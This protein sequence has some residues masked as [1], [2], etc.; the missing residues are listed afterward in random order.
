MTWYIYIV[1]CSDESLYTGITR[2]VASRITQHNGGEGAKYTRTR[3][4]VE[5][6]YMEKANSRS[7]ALRREYEIKRMRSAGKR[8]LI[9]NNNNILRG[10]GH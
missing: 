7:A 4:P 1:R 2:D 9:A 8:G 10:Q 6:V 3:L 5:L